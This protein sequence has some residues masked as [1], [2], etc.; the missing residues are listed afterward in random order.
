MKNDYGLGQDL[1]IADN[2]GIKQ[3]NKSSVHWGMEC[4]FQ[5][6]KADLSTSRQAEIFDGE[7]KRQK[8]E[9]W[10]KGQMEEV[11]PSDLNDTKSKTG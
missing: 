1:L 3:A 9:T 2:F 10:W 7:K 11:A 8:W 6:T 5:A 4:T